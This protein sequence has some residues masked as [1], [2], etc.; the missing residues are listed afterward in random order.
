[1]AALHV[2]GFTVQGLPFEFKDGTRVQRVNKVDAAGNLMTV[3]FMMVDENLEAIWK[4][5]RRLPFADRE[6]TVISRDALIG[7]KGRAARPQDLMDVQNLKD[8]DR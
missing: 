7:M 3:D 6:V 2:G 5:R 4:T 1:M 8:I